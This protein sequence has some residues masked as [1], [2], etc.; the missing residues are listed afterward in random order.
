MPFASIRRIVQTRKE[1]YKIKPGL[2]G[3]LSKKSQ[4]EGRG[5]IAE[6]ERNK[7]AEAVKLFGQK[8]KRV[9]PTFDTNR[10]F[11]PGCS[12]PKLIRLRFRLHSISIEARIW[13]VRTPAHGLVAR[14]SR[15]RVRA[16]SR[17]AKIHGARRSMNPPT[18]TPAL[19][20]LSSSRQRKSANNSSG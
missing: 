4:N 16:A 3:L 7:N 9:S 1:I 13:L 11:E 2:Y 17:R 8:R 15:L 12:S 5:I 18:R 20:T 14:P 19:R 10:Y 6:T